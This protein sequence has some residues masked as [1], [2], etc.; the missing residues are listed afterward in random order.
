M[1]QGFLLDRINSKTAGTAITGHDNLI[2][3]ILPDEAQAALV[4]VQLAKS[5]AKITL[6]TPIFQFVPIAGFHRVMGN[7]LCHCYSPGT[8]NK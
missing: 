3:Q 7:K 6:N 2:M 8:V 1:V 5:R 4:F